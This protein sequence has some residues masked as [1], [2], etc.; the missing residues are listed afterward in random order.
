VAA[1][2]E[3]DWAAASVEPADVAVASRSLDVRDLRAALRKL[4]SFARRR[5]CITVPADG[6]L[7]P[8]LLAHEAVGR[9]LRRRG[10]AALAL[11]VLAGM[12]IR[13]E[14]S[15]L[16]HA[17]VRQYESPGAALESLHRM[18][19]PQDEREGRALERYVAEHIVQTVDAGGRRV[20]TQSP[21]IA[22]RWA[23]IAWDTSGDVR[24]E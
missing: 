7:Y 21:A 17:R 23:F 19:A 15:Y 22:V 2:W 10:D 13:A 20:W 24:G 11:S 18:I 3:D 12:G 16:E 14:V 8:G 1:G 9:P 5:V 4:E 6:L